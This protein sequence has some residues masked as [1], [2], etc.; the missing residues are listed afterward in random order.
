[1]LTALTLRPN[2]SCVN[3]NLMTGDSTYHHGDLRAALLKAAEAEIERSGYEN[4]SLRELAASLGVSRAAPYRHFVDRRAL[5][6]ALAADGFRQ[7]TESHRAAKGRTARTRLQA[8]GR[9]YLAFAAA[10]PQLYRLMFVADLFSAAAGPLDPGLL[11]AG[12]ES[13]QVFED[14]VAATLGDVGDK[15]VKAATITYMSSTY[16]FALLRIND[17]LKP[18]MYGELR[19]DDL[20]DALLSVKVTVLPGRSGKRGGGRPPRIVSSS[21]GLTGRSSSHRPRE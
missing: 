14:M 10:R 12:G 21:P 3:I 9:A 4:L 5:L 6:S 18:F 20:V 11:E 17:R 8:A 2:V 19:P 13:Y 15:A 1:M 7:L 16:G